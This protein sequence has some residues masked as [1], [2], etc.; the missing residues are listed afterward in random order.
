MSQLKA[1]QLK[2]AS[3]G[4]L[5]VGGNNGTG[6]SLSIGSAGQ[7]L[8]VVDSSPTW[9]ANDTLTSSDGGTSIT[10]TDTVINFVS[11]T[12]SV[13][14]FGVEENAD[15]FLTMTAS[16]GKLTLAGDGSADDVDVVISPKGEGE[17]IIGTSGGGAIQAED[18]FD[19]KLLGGEGAGNLIL[20]GGGTGKVYYA[21]DASDPLREV[22]TLGDIESAIGDSLVSQTRS[23]FAG[24]AISFA[25]NSKAVITSVIAHI[26]GLVIEED[27]FTV[28]PSD[29][30]V[31]FSGLPYIL[32]AQDSVVF[33]YEITV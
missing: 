12:K 16:V 20:M 26:N 14:T 13:A 17:V 3:A 29:K 15:S 6:S 28:D 25:L 24:N 5:L 21:D 10:T 27:Y 1:K 4:D 11:D 22:A 31:T 23:E 2:L 19:L 7:I 18:G 9:S 33:T 32:D 8:R 30:T